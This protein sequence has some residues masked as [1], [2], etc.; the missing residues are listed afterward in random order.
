MDI[1]VRCCSFNN[2]LVFI[3]SWFPVLLLFGCAIMFCCLLCH[4]MDV[5][6]LVFTYSMRNFVSVV[7]LLFMLCVNQ[8]ILCNFT[9]HCLFPLPFAHFVIIFNDHTKV[10]KNFVQWTWTYGFFMPWFFWGFYFFL[11]FCILS[12]YIHIIV[13]VV[14]IL[15][16]CF[17]N[18]FVFLEVYIF[19]V[20]V[21]CLAVACNIG[22][23]I[24]LMYYYHYWI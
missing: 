6:Y 3:Y 11:Y 18:L 8:D 5:I 2:T 22:H 13:I 10:W 17:D 19:T 16:N 21:K 23:L 20:H 24:N 14:F 15:F 7:R 4:F 12:L 9:L 1:N